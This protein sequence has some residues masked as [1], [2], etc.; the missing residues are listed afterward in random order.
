MRLSG[1]SPMTQAG[2][3]AF[4]LEYLGHMGDNIGKTFDEIDPVMKKSLSSYGIGKSDWD[5]TYSQTKTTP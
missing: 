4:G 3:Q 1:L 2:R 5:I